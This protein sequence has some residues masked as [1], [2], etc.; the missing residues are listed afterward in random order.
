MYHL[1][2][3]KAKSYMGIVCATQ[4]KPDVYVSEKQQADALVESGYFVLEGESENDNPELK[5]ETGNEEG[6]KDAEN[7]D[8]FDEANEVEEDSLLIELQTMSKAELVN[9]ADKNG[10]DLTGCNKKDEIYAKIVEF[11]AKADAA[12]AALREEA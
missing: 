10:I 8:L 5:K 4:A 1:R 3:C 12:R 7:V 9:Y 2:L 11:I 6:K